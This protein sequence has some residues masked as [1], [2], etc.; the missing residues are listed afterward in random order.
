MIR[1]YKKQGEKVKLN[2]EELEDVQSF[3][4][5]AS[6]VTA[7]NVKYK[8]GKVP[9]KVLKSLTLSEKFEMP[10]RFPIKTKLRIFNT[11]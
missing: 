7:T 9:K 2:G 5:L 1:T 8:I 10:H 4:Y 11:V 6:I 3:T